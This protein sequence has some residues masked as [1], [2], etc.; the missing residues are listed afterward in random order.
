MVLD[1][2]V[3]VLLNPIE[4]LKTSLWWLVDRLHEVVDELEEQCLVLFWETQHPADDVD[5][6]VLRVLHGS[7][8]DGFARSDVTH[9]I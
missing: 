6:N 7:I 5:R 8:D 2:S 1:L 9:R 4:A 3:D